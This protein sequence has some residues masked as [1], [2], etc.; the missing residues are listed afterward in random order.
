MNFIKPDRSTRNAMYRIEAYHRD[1]TH[2]V[3]V[4]QDLTLTPFKKEAG[5]FLPEIVDALASD[6]TEKY[7][8]MC[9]VV[10]DYR[11]EWRERDK[12]EQEPK[13]IHKRVYL[14]PGLKRHEFERQLSDRSE[15]AADLKLD[16]SPTLPK[17]I[18][19]PY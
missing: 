15:E 18:Y 6:V 17:H 7:D 11:K 9:E 3:Y 5:E 14:K 8:V 19:I 10:R 2:E 12:V 16:R 4:T 13:P 1:L